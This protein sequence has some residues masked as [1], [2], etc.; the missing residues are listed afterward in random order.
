MINKDNRKGAILAAA[1]AALFIA[2]PVAV[3]AG[4]HSEAEPTGHCVGA[5]SCKGTSACATANSSC[6]GQNACKGQ[7]WTDTTKAE[8]DEA[9]GEFEEA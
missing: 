7:G 6:K 3:Y 9:G 4:A 2:S 8:C 1:A 5:N